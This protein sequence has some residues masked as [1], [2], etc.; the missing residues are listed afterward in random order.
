MVGKPGRSGGAR[1]TGNRSIKDGKDLAKSDGGPV[2]PKGL[3]AEQ[4]KVWDDIVA[5]LP[6]GTMKKVDAALLQILSA[7][8]CAMRKLNK[9]F[10][11]DPG[12]KDIRQG[13]NQCAQKILQISAVVG[14]SPADRK[15]IQLGDGNNE[16]DDLKKFL[17]GNRGTANDR[18]ANSQG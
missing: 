14:L 17:Q 13:F 18:S 9:L 16:D 3:T 2:Q 12:D 1:H 6:D 8:I 5:C 7:Y 15:R 4:K 11:N 10:L